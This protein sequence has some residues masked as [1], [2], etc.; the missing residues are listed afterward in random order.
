GRRVWLADWE[1][2]FLNDRYVDLAVVANMIVTNEVEEKVYL[3]EYFGRPA[4][5]YELARLFVMRQVGHLFYVLGFLFMSSLAGSKS[6]GEGVPE[7]GEF[8]RRIWAREVDLA[9]SRLTYGRVHLA[10]LREN[11]RTA[12]FGEALRIVSAGMASA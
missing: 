1:A 4:D 10:R 5:E 9:E 11:A 7:Y 3:K 2:A 6:T 8:Q 12:R